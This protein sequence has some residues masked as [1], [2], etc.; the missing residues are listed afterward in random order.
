MR[1]KLSALIN[2]HTALSA[3]TDQP[4]PARASFQL[5]R[6]SKAIA[7]EL[8]AYEAARKALCERYG[9]VSTDGTKYDIAKKNQKSFDEEYAQLIATEVELGTGNKDVFDSIDTPSARN[10]NLDKPGDTKGGGGGRGKSVAEQLAEDAVKR[11]QIELRGAERISQ[12]INN[13]LQRD[14]QA[15]GAL[16]EAD[17]KKQLDEATSVYNAKLKIQAAEEAKAKLIKNPLERA[18]KERELAQDRLDIESEYQEQVK[19]I[20]FDA[21]QERVTTLSQFLEQQYTLLKDKSQSM[22]SLINSEAMQRVMT[23]E[24]TAR[25][26][27]E[28]AL[29]D[30]NREIQQLDEKRALFD[31]ETEEYK[32]LTREIGVLEN[33][34]GSII[35]ETNRNV[36]EGRRQD[37]ADYRAYG[38]SLR[39]LEQSI[40]DDA[41]SMGREEIDAM[42][43]RGGSKKAIR[44]AESALTFQTEQLRHARALDDIAKEKLEFEERKHTWAQWLEFKKLI[45]EKEGLEDARHTRELGRMNDQRLAEVRDK[46][47]QIASTVTGVLRNAFEAGIGG[48]F[49]SMLQQASGFLKQLAFKIIESEAFKLLAK[50]LTDP[51]KGEDDKETGD[52]KPKEGGIMGALAKI[53]FGDQAK[54]D[55]A[56]IAT[57]NNTTATDL[58]TAA[59]DRLNST[60]RINGAGGSGNSSP[61]SNDF[62]S[63]FDNLLSGNFSGLSHEVGNRI[64]AGTGNTTSAVKDGNT[65]THGFLGGIERFGGLSVELLSQIAGGAGQRPAWATALQA[66]VQLAGAYFS[67][68]GGSGGDSGGSSS[69]HAAGGYITGPGSGTSDSIVT[70]LSNG[71]YVISSKAVRHFGVGFFDQLNAM[72]PALRRADGGYVARGPRFA[73]RGSSS[74]SSSSSHVEQ[75]YHTWNITTPDAQSFRRSTAQIQA[76]MF[77][78]SARSRTRIR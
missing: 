26:L 63:V 2:S 29:S 54:A 48:F 78:S 51:V 24:Q 27:G 57:N 17:S 15:R 46:L 72:R 74:G 37:L 13:Q 47:K 50:L 75:H 42:I 1:I 22:V 43:R 56:A 45:N 53:I 52:R 32:R 14:V 60:I 49:R 55:T 5:A 66:G 20:E 23:A 59:I 25:K 9:K 12:Q 65:K 31:E 8:D 30:H 73:S 6:A 41:L 16:I 76:E 18:A 71:E 62:V 67:S 39:T 33:R 64:G 77:E 3:L 70:R 36:A 4:L 10:T 38:E 35:A 34:R 11:A 58:N 19:Q 40:M 68:R 21:Q 69:G 44:Q 28:I 7:V 61:I